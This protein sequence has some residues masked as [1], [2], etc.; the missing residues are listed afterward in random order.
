MAR[1]GRPSD[2][3]QQLSCSCL[4]GF[5]NSKQRPRHKA[6]TRALLQPH[7][8]WATL[9]HRLHPVNESRLGGISCHLFFP[10]MRFSNPHSAEPT[11]I[12]PN[13]SGFLASYVL[14]RLS[15]HGL[16]CLLSSAYHTF[17]SKDYSPYRQRCNLHPSTRN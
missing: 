3:S 17:Q 6:A 12:Y 5:P 8:N 2:G 13:R 4:D 14:T 11:R 10:R 16:Y 15:H 1:L 9:P 7:S